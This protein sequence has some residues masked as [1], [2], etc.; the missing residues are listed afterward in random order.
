MCSLYS[1]AGKAGAGMAATWAHQCQDRTEY[2]T[3]P[4]P[5]FAPRA[6]IQGTIVSVSVKGTYLGLRYKQ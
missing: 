1:Q 3:V 5:L 4:A 6:L 2:P